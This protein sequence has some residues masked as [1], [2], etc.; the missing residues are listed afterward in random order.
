MDPAQFD[1]VKRYVGFDDRASALL[2]ELA[3]LVA[4]DIPPLIDDFYAAIVRD[5]DAYRVI[6]GGRE[7]IDRLKCT[8]EEWLASSLRGPHDLEWMAARR[9]IGLVHVRVG[10]Q[11]RFMLT[12][13]NRVR[14]G[15]VR[16]VQ[17]VYAAD[18]ERRAAAELAV[19]QLL[20]LELAVMLDSYHDYLSS[21]IR[22]NERLA[23]IGQLAASVGHE[24][25]NPLGIIESSLFLARQR[26]TK[27]AIDDAPLEKHVQRMQKQVT[28]CSAIIKNLMDLAR[29]RPP[30]RRTQLLRPLVERTL[31]EHA[32]G[33][34]IELDVDAE[35]QIDV[36]ADDLGH[37]LGNLIGNASEAMDGAGAV[38]I[39]AG[40]RQGGTELFVQDY[41]PGVS[42]EIRDRIFDALFTT[43]ARGTGLGLALCNRIVRAHGGELELVPSDR[44]ACF[45]VWFP[46][47]PLPAEEPGSS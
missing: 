25:R 13:M 32:S 45:R 6:T 30:R 27:L 34:T 26:V 28:Q 10:L 15:L 37:V 47:I 22:S 11:Q 46:D 41:G 1:G 35:L 42:P 17:R 21:S 33:T 7:Q 38:S 24:L 31:E 40:R 44:G 16:S 14:T 36:D 39:R 19:H 8:L 5:P 3:P 43:K 29:D 12:A 2:G 18:T 4:A 23:T 20:D 9:R